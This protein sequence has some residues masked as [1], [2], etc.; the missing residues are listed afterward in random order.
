MR[1]VACARNPSVVYASSIGSSGPPQPVSSGSWIQWSITHRLANPAASA[2]CA[3]SVRV[4]RIAPPP[5]GNEKDGSWSPSRIGR[6][7]RGV[8]KRLGVLVAGDRPADT[9]QPAADPDP[10]GRGSGPLKMRTAPLRAERG[11]LVVELCDVVCDQE[12]LEVDHV[13]HPDPRFL[14]DR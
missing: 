7:L 4:D 11:C 2:A 5:P 12:L 10:V 8:R 9:D 13:V 3:T 6:A 14:S 1:S